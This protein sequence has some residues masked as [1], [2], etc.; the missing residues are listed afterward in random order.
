[1]PPLELNSIWLKAA[2]NLERIAQAVIGPC[3][4]QQDNYH[5]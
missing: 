4:P 5:D 2:S 1:M 3:H